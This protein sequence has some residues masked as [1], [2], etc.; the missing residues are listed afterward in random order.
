MPLHIKGICV[1]SM[2]PNIHDMWQ[3]LFLDT[4]KT[5]KVTFSK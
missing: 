5:Q 2:H 3:I 4:N 1:Q